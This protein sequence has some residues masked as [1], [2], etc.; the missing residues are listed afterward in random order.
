MIYFFTGNNDFQIRDES[1]KW[2]NH[3]I[4]KYGDFNFFH[5]KDILGVSK[6]YLAEAMLSSSFF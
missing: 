6:D 2:K 1:Q 3:F 5:I 4:S